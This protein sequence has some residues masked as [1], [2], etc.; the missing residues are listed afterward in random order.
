MQQLEIYIK[1][2]RLELFK[3][4]EITLNQQIKDIRE[5]ARI[6]SDFTQSFTVPASKANNKIFKHYYRLD[7]LNGFDGRIKARAELKLNGATFR[8]GYIILTGVQTEKDVAKNYKI[9]FVGNA[10]S[11]KDIF[12]E[13]KL[14]DL[15][16]LD[17]FNL[18]YNPTDIQDALS[19]GI[20]TLVLG[21]QANPDVLY[22]DAIIA[23]MITHTKFLYYDSVNNQSGTDGNL[24]PN[25]GNT[26]HG[27]KWD[28]LKFSIRVSVIV[29]AI[30][31]LYGINFSTDFFNNSNSDYYGLY[32]WLH[33]K[34]G[35]VEDEDA[36]SS[37]ST[38]K[39][40][41]K[42]PN[43]TIGGMNLN[44]TTFVQSGIP[45]VYEKSRMIY[46][47]K[48]SSSSATFDFVVKDSSGTI[49]GSRYGM[50]GAT[51]YVIPAITI[52]ANG[53]YKVY[54][55]SA[56]N[57]S[58]L[59]TSTVYVQSTDAEGFQTQS[60]P[61]F[62][63][64]QSLATIQPFVITDNIPKMKIIDFITGLFKMFNLTLERGET[65][66]DFTVKTVEGYYN[67]GTEIDISKYIDVSSKT[68][69]PM[70]PYKSVDFRFEDNKTYTAELSEQ[71]NGK[72]FG[73]LLYKGKSSGNYVGTEYSVKLP[74]EKM[75]YN[76]VFDL[77]DG[78]LKSPQY[79]WFVNK[80]RK[81]YLGKPLLHYTSKVSS[82]TSIAWYGT[83][84]AYTS[85]SNYH[86]PL[87]SENLLATGQSLNFNNET[88]EYAGGVNENSLFNTYHK[89]TY[90]R[91]FE[92][93]QRLVN[94]TAYLP[95]KILLDY[96]LAD[97]F[98]IDGTKYS[99]NK[100]KTNLQSGKSTLELLNMEY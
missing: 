26:T 23:P 95:L 40:L 7:V 47:I 68:V 48:V 88:D 71:I 91:L 4:E 70:I 86:I 94:I 19:N 59:S 28:D 90:E 22:S 79:G 92:Q 99:I 35:G 6:F 21:D 12:E 75:R 65:T 58:V 45:T 89:V 98:V 54:V 76:R 11:L 56:D 61:T 1:S 39:K 36:V 29:K 53:T 20:D 38:T 24:Y 72:P 64:T 14:S 81:E 93:G 43:L 97:T 55:T 50:T 49:M 77:S 85:L 73:R 32:M 46:T 42:M 78:T 30:E 5:P 41:V 33:R 31:D 44:E 84:L 10:I 37:G 83:T 17:N 63:A 2:N 3:D 51:S 57:F 60:T 13:D 69:N 27:L 82:G 87:N 66:R 34:Q 18:D 62:T 67:G 80:D 16:F 96:T 9:Q 100:I 8:E 15:P 74:F 25:A 52:T